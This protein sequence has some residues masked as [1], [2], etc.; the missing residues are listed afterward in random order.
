GAVV[1]EDDSPLARV[2]LCPERGN[3]L[4]QQGGLVPRGDQDH[5]PGPAA[6]LG[7]RRDVLAERPEVPGAGRAERN[8]EPPRER[9]QAEGKKGLPHGRTLTTPPGRA[10]GEAS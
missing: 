1:D 4:G 8:A 5:D 7:R 9:E 10:R 2:V 3:S 6:R